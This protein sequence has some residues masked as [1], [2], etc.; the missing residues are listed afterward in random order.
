MRRQQ[1][2]ILCMM[3]LWVGWIQS[4]YA[5]EQVMASK[6]NGL[7][8]SFSMLS[9]SVSGNRVTLKGTYARDS[10]SLLCQKN[11]LTLNTKNEYQCDVEVLKSPMVVDFFAV[12]P[13]GEIEKI[14]I[15]LKVPH[16]EESVETLPGWQKTHQLSLGVGYHQLSLDTFLTSNV[17]AVLGLD[18]TLFENVFFH[19]SGNGTAFPFYSNRSDL[20]LR[21]VGAEA[22]FGY[23]LPIFSPMIRIEPVIGAEFFGLFDSQQGRETELFMDYGLSYQQWLDAHQSFKFQGLLYSGSRGYQVSAG[24]GF[25]LNETADM[26]LQ[27]VF[28]QMKQSSYSQDGFRSYS[29]RTLI[30]F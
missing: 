23:R 16:L 29:V 6:Q 8:Q 13:L 24:Y 22:N 15:L 27:F 7:I 20:S 5:V 28:D 17:E 4:S 1:F 11:P 9:S 30:Q 25:G 26:T 19:L 3:S 10:W 2:S 14:Q 21:K 18:L 12:G